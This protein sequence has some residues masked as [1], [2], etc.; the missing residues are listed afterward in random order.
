MDKLRGLTTFLDTAAYGIF[1]ITLVDIAVMFTGIDY[2]I[3][4]IDN[5]IKF[6]VSIVS[7]IYFAFFK[8]PHTIKLNKLTRESKR[9]ENERTRQEIE[10]RWDEYVD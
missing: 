4:T 1:G 6:V 2:D 9:L 7:V 5:S 8:I 10:Q 3:I